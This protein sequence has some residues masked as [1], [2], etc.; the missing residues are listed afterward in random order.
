[1]RS[2][3]S[4]PGPHQSCVPGL[5]SPRPQRIRASAHSA[6]RAPALLKPDHRVVT[7]TS[8]NRLFKASGLYLL[9]KAGRGRP[10][11]PGNQFAFAPWM[12]PPAIRSH[13]S[14]AAAGTTATIRQAQEL[15]RFAEDTVIQIS[16][17]RNRKSA[18]DC[19][20]PVDDETCLW[21]A[22]ENQESSLRWRQ[23]RDHYRFDALSKVDGDMEDE[24]PGLARERA[25]NPASVSTPN[26][27]TP[28]LSAVCARAGGCQPWPTPPAAMSCGTT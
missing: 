16:A 17:A 26:S 20:E 11:R 27:R 15:S 21:K 13:G 7:M 12:F 23:P 6:P 5:V 4:H 1:M 10:Q 18:R 24:R 2:E 3:A 8:G 25:E 19:A 22:E 14:P 9:V 28:D